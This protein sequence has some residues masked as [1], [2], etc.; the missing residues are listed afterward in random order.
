M[1]YNHNR[2]DKRSS[3]NVARG[4][5]LDND[6]LK[7]RRVALFITV[8]GI[9]DVK[10]A[11]ESG[12]INKR[13]K[14]IAVNHCRKDRNSPYDAKIAEQIGRDLKRLDLQ[15]I[16]VDD[17]MESSR[18]LATITSIVQIWGK[19]DFA[20][21]DLCGLA[22]PSLCAAMNKFQALL[23]KKARISMTVCTRVRQPRL[24]EQ[25]KKAFGGELDIPTLKILSTPTTSE[26]LSP[27]FS[28][29]KDKKSDI[30]AREARR[31]HIDNFLWQIQAIVA[32]LN[33]RMIEIVSAMQYSDLT[34]MGLVVFD[35][36]KQSGDNGIFHYISDICQNAQPPTSNKTA[37]SD[38]AKKAWVTRRQNVSAKK[39]K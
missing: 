25:W 7:P 26:W 5:A 12:L 10:E 23:D 38:R 15:H 39:G 30:A 2:N 4:M 21:I 29:S 32:S 28:T 11:I 18:G 22:T 3:K 33:H 20:F 37:H 13:T 17:F 27:L 36:T 6:G 24:I 14:I 16:V 35:T 31:K 9:P 1:S 8:P 34:G 19:I